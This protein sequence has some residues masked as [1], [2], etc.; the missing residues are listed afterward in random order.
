MI[1]FWKISLPLAICL[2]AL[3][4]PDPQTEIP[5]AAQFCK[6]SLS[7]IGHA[8]PTNTNER[9]RWREKILQELGQ[10]RK[11]LAETERAD[12]AAMSAASSRPAQDL[13]LTETSDG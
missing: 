5:S 4:G 3:G 7:V 11:G 8:R 2:S 10:L 1:N 6:V 9:D 13:P 12:R